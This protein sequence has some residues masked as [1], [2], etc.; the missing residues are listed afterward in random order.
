[1]RYLK[2][3]QLTDLKIIDEKRDLESYNNGFLN[4][5]L[6]FFGFSDPIAAVKLKVSVN[7][8]HHIRN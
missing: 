2:G 7:P 5:A 6:P 1:L 3:I 4:L 8:I